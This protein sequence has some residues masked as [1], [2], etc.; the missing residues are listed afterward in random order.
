MACYVNYYTA[1]LS[2]RQ[3]DFD[4]LHDIFSKWKLCKSGFPQI[5]QKTF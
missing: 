2:D 1:C 4:L 5:K 3:Q